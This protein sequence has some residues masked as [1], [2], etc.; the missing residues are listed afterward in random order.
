MLKFI[1]IFLILTNLILIGFVKSEVSSRSLRKEYHDRMRD[2][3]PPD[4]LREFTDDEVRGLLE[5]AKI[6]DL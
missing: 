6:F 4:C 2:G 1:L 3:T 5:R